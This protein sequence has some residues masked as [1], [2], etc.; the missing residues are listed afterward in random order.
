MKICVRDFRANLSKYLRGTEM[1][2]VTING[3]VVAR[4]EP[5]LSNKITHGKIKSYHELPQKEKEA[6]VNHAAR[7]SAKEQEKLAGP[8]VAKARKEIAKK[9]VEKY[10][11]FGTYGCGCKKEGSILCK[12]HHR[13]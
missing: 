5:A 7:E 8:N 13:S 1:I 3:L 11:G 10:V 4:V 12:T 2:E 6:I 9:K